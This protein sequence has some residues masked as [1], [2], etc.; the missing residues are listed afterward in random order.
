MAEPVPVLRRDDEVVS[1][2]WDDEGITLETKL[3]ETFHLTRAQI[4][5]SLVEE[6]EDV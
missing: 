3:G 1:G 4:I 6:N 2:W 5:D